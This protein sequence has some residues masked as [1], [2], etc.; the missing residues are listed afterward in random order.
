MAEVMK[1]RNSEVDLFLKRA[2]RWQTEMR[3][4]REILLESG[5]REELK[6]GKPCYCTEDKNIAIMQPFKPHLSLMFFEGA[7]LEDKRNLLREQGKNSRSARR[8][9]ITDVSY[10]EKNKKAIQG[11]IKQARTI[12]VQPERPSKK[13]ADPIPMELE[14]RFS[15]DPDY[16]TA[17]EA[18]TPGRQRGYLLHFS[19][20]KQSKTRQNRIDRCRE[21]ILEGK[22]INER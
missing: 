12:I 10:T 9:E 8:L 1:G 3:S 5:L 17:F 11:L 14:H 20:A 16:R 4:L 2:S 18:L 21:Q 13:P 7:F 6:W 22:G 15:G 19:E